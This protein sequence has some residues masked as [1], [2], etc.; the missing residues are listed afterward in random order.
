MSNKIKFCQ[1][2]GRHIEK[3]ERFCRNCGYNLGIAEHPQ[4]LKSGKRRSSK[5]LVIAVTSVVLAA[6]L[7]I[8]GFWYPGFI[9]NIFTDSGAADDSVTM[10]KAKEQSSWCREH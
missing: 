3:G 1:N 8:T 6:S 2:C 5:P 4:S 7:A 10:I 9:R